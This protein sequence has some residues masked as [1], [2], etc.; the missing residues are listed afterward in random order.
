MVYADTNQICADTT[1]DLFLRNL[2]KWAHGTMK[3]IARSFMEHKGL[4]AVG[5]PRAPQ[6]IIT[7]GHVFFKGRGLIL[8][9]LFLQRFFQ[10]ELFEETTHGRIYRGSTASCHGT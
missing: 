9:Y 4:I 8:W 1:M 2:P 10:I 7:S 5:W 6:W 3:S